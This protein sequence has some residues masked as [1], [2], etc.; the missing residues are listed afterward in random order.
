MDRVGF[1]WQDLGGGYWHLDGGVLSLD[2]VEI[3]VDI[4]LRSLPAEY[5]A[6]LPEATQVAIRARCGGDLASRRTG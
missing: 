3:D 1:R 4:V 2:V 5:V 6:T